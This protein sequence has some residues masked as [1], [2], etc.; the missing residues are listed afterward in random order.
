MKRKLEFWFKTYF[1]FS[2]KE[3]VGFLLVV[4]LLFLLSFLPAF[5]RWVKDQRESD[6]YA[7]YLQAA[8]SLEKAGFLVV[9]SPLPGFNPQDTVKKDFKTSQIERINRI[10][11]SEADS[12]T[13][14]IVPGI[15][16]ATAGRIIKYRE[17]LGGFVAKTQL[18][19]VYGMKAETAEEVWEYFEFDPGIRTKIPINQAEAADL[20]KHPY[21][22]YSEAKVIVA[23][24]NQHGDFQNA[25]DLLKIRIFKKEWVDKIAPYLN[26]D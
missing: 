16:P 5:I 26:F 23:Y 17:N 21:I 25:E 9:S 11:F 13:L 7:E 2:R 10:P 8:D 22:S 14:Q 24:R 15:G 6:R 4:P 18:M 20:S 3:T 1:G 12:I 19:E